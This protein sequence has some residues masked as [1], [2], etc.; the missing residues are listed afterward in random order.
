MNSR[1]WRTV[2]SNIPSMPL[3]PVQPS[4]S[5]QNK[6][7]ATSVCFFLFSRF[8]ISL[9]RSPVENP[10]SE[11]QIPLRDLEWTVWIGLGGDQLVPRGVKPAGS[12]R[13]WSKTMAGLLTFFWPCNYLRMSVRRKK[14]F[15]FY[16]YFQ[17]FVSCTLAFLMFKCVWLEKVC[18]SSQ[19]TRRVSTLSQT[20]VVIRICQKCL[21]TCSQRRSFVL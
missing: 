21:F 3:I 2:V 5:L 12:V 8:S 1:H 4:E 9:K 19:K 17:F 13:G 6:R 18:L 16:V 7:E 20:T 15:A 10:A 14:S 11:C